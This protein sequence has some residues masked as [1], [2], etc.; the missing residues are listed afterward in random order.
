LEDLYLA[1]KRLDD[2]RTGSSDSVSLETLLD[3]YGVKTES[4]ADRLR[5][6]QDKV[7]SYKDRDVILDEVSNDVGDEY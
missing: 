3:S 4:R 1:E 6:L 7:A 2:S 5:P